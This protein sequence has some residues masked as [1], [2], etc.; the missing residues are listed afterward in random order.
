MN[1]ANLVSE[2]FGF[3]PDNFKITD[4]DLKADIG[5]Y[6]YETKTLRDQIRLRPDTYIGSD[7]GISNEK[8]WVATME[9]NTFKCVYDSY[10]LASA[11]IGISKEV[12][13]NATDN[14]ERSRIENIDPG[15]IEIVM[16][17]NCLSV[18]NY[19]K[20]IDVVIH[21]KEGCWVPQ[22]LFGVL[23]T[24]DCY[25][26]SVER[27]KIGRNGYGVKLTNIFSTEFNLR[28]ADPKR[29]LL[30]TQKWSDGMQTREDPIIKRFD[31][32]EGL[33][34]GY[35][36]ILFNP[37]FQ[38]F[39][40]NSEL[41]EWLPAMH[42]V[43]LYKAMG[44]SF[45]AQIETTFNGTK[46]DFRDIEKFFSCHLPMDPLR[47][48]L[49]WE[50]SD[51][52]NAFMIADTP[53]KGT[54][55]AYVNG[56]PVHE[57]NHVNSY[58]KAIFVKLK[59]HFETKFKKKVTVVHLKKHITILLRVT[60]DKPTFDSQIK[61]RLV[62]PKN[63][64]IKIPL[65]IQNAVMKWQ[66]DNEL[67]KIFNMKT[68]ASKFARK[69]K[70]H[71]RKVTD[72]V[73]AGVK[74]ESHKC[75]LI[76]TEGETGCTLALKGLKFLPGGLEYNGVYPLRGIVMNTT[77]SSKLRIDNNVELS[78]IMQI[79]GAEKGIDYTIPENYAKLRYG[80]IVFMCDT[81][82]DGYHIVGL[83]LNFVFQYLKTLAPFEFALSLMTPVA[84]AKKG[85]TL[86]P[87]YYHKQYLQWQKNTTDL[88]SWKVSYKK[89]LGSWN[90][91]D[92]VL[93][94]LFAK[95]IITTY[96]VDPH[97]D[98]TLK[99][100]FDVKE[101]NSRKLWISDYDE[102]FI[103]HVTAP[104]PVTEFFQEEYRSFCKAVVKRTIPRLMD[105]MKPIHRKILYCMFLKFPKGGKKKDPIKLIQFAG[106]VMEKAGYH[107]GE[108][109]LYNSIIIMG[110]RYLTGPNNL[111][112]LNGEGNH[113]DRR[114][115]GKDAS[116]ARYLKTS[117]F[118]VAHYIYRKEDEPL[119]EY[120]YDEGERIEPKEMY[121]VIPMAIVNKTEG[122]GVGW[123]T[124]IPAHNPEVVTQWV[125][126]WVLEVK[127][128]R[129]TSLDDLVIDV[130]NKPEL[131]PYWKGY[132]GEIRRIANSPYEVFLN[133]GSFTKQLYMTCVTELPA[134]MTIEYYKRWLT[135]EEEIYNDYGKPPED[136]KPRRT[137]ILRTFNQHKPPPEVDFRISGMSH[138]DVDKLKLVKTIRLSNM[139][140]IDKD[141]K[142]RKFNYV[143]EILCEW[144]KNRL[145]IYKKRKDHIIGSYSE[146]L[147][148]TSLKYQFVM[149]VVEGRLILKNRDKKTQIVPYMKSKGYPYSGDKSF[150]KMPIGSITRN[151]LLQLQKQIGDIKN[152]LEYYKTTW[153]GDLWLNDLKE[154]KV[155]IAKLYAK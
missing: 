131:I 25:D 125:I 8:V 148:T 6:Q 72:A 77:K 89:G 35:T 4:M 101:A 44:M 116:P 45:A 82:D 57:G 17:N 152:K 83:L 113:G 28:V 3:Q 22:Q 135:K 118:D 71:V 10:P 136:D 102:D 98:S 79:L 76:L 30:Y 69:K 120:L 115:R 15:I 90:T 99:L 61:R 14:V 26:D 134:E 123:S 100:A 24:S 63:I 106:F 58:L 95:P 147:K 92:P 117:L 141:E 150:L 55:A 33:D 46:L 38:Y 68:K 1:E 11:I 107:H 93:K 5:G 34:C 133:L 112:L 21:H 119:F 121:P 88:S 78:G 12:L 149:D 140:L 31:Q 109:A 146:K 128:Q 13:D 96:A 139:V 114:L 110:Q 80:K 130:A 20:P 111:P 36:Q 144:C 48:Q 50:S 138:P 154:L 65:S 9:D 60:L 122:I 73:K 49:K 52:K 19:G 91:E 67:R 43:M 129:G 145:V 16:T 23:L 74:G 7:I 39:Y 153:Y 32:V 56:T 18:K 143:F 70:V 27:Y 142:P 42:N 47:N 132:T 103:P 85:R 75:S 87:F 151:K 81:D 66:I 137:P 105:G 29:Q 97:T 64:K 108:Q 59:E 104:R 155:E 53:G 126:D 2:N 41:N 62:Q 37:D 40:Q 54:S 51:G 124:K 84:E 127:K 86:I 94:K